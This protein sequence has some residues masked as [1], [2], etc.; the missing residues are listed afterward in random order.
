MCPDKE[1]LNLIPRN[2]LD[3]TERTPTL[4]G[5]WPCKEKQKD[6]LERRVSKTGRALIM[7]VMAQ[8]RAHLLSSIWLDKE[9]KKLTDKSSVDRTG[10]IHLRL[11]RW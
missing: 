2:L 8:K 3:Q 5:R 9:R 10:R 11:V 1:W 4:H 6:K 7:K